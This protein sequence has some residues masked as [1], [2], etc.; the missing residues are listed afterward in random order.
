MQPAL[1]ST[2]Q[3]TCGRDEP[4]PVCFLQRQLRVAHQVQ[5]AGIHEASDDA[6]VHRNHAQGTRVLRIGG[7]IVAQPQGLGLESPEPREGASGGL[8]VQLGHAKGLPVHSTTIIVC[9][10]KMAATCRAMDGQYSRGHGPHLDTGAGARPAPVWCS[11]WHRLWKVP[12]GSTV[13][14]T[15]SSSR[16]CRS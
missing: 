15:I 13:S 9:C 11:C 3:P 2:S 10:S 16:G 6:G 12:A 4:Q 14:R 8:S 5:Q 1:R 7:G